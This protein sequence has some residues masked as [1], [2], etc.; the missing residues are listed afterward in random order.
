MNDI[1]LI[2]FDCDG[3]LVDSE[4]ISNQVFADYLSNHGLEI[5]AQECIERFVGLS[6]STCKSMVEKDGYPMPDSFI[7]KIYEATMDALSR[8]LEPICGI[9]DALA[10]VSATKSVCVASSGSPAKIDNSLTKAGLL[11]HFGDFVYSANQVSNGKPA[12]DL[13]LFA[14][15]QMETSPERSIVIEDSR[16]GVQAGVAAGMTVVGFTGGSHIHP[17]HGDALRSLGAYHILE[18]MAGLPALLAT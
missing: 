8:D 1:D 14:A 17:G 15:S 2:I 10:S 13:F 11:D 6:M 9:H 18:D 4:I 12:P 3:V 16:A 7:D 5:T